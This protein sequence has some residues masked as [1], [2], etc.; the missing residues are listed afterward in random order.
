LCGACWHSLLSAST[1][2]TLPD[3][4]AMEYRRLAR[5]CLRVSR[6]MSSEEGRLALVE[7]ARVWA[8]LAEE[9]GA[10]LQSLPMSE[11]SEPVMQQQEQVRP[12]KDA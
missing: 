10:A 4:R 11:N 1:G 2:A 3:H 6:S 8:R 9:Q 5:E 7:M 12:K